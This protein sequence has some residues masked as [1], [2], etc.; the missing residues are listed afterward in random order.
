[1]KIKVTTRVWSMILG[2]GLAVG[3]I[4]PVGAQSV[5]PAPATAQASDPVAVV[6]AFHAAGDDIEAA[7]SL[8][9]DDVVIELLPPP[10]NTPG[11][12]KGKAEARAFIQWRIATN[13]KRM[14][15][16][17]A[18]VTADAG[19][20]T[21]TGNVGVASDLFTKLG[22]GTVGHTFKAEVEDGKLKYYSGKLAPE[23]QQ[24][25]AEAL[26]LASQPA[27]MPRTGGP[28]LLPLTIAIGIIVLTAGA[29]L[30]KRHA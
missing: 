19:R 18:Q 4:G 1:M 7:L 16:G 27:G 15:A 21:V 10:P 26:R 29:A 22:L 5:D 17:D 11:I 24:R 14:R 8:L 23:E 6:D 13:Q 12:W 2:F 28:Q 30:R 25:V 20:Y 3:I 9:T